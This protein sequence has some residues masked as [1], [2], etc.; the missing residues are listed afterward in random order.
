ML[1]KKLLSTSSMVKQSLVPHLSVEECF[2]E[3]IRFIRPLN[4]NDNEA[5]TNLLDRNGVK[6]QQVHAR[7]GIFDD[8]HK[9]VELYADYLNAIHNYGQNRQML[10]WMH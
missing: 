1:T 6:P 3:N 5:I 9:L 10:C 2:P 8:H 7:Y 4:V